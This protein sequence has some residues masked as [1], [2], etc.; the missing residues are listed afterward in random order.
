MK[1]FITDGNR[2][3]VSDTGGVDILLKSEE[4]KWNPNSGI[5]YKIYDDKKPIGTVG[6]LYFF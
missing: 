4:N 1:S 2:A 6:M 3:P 5:Q